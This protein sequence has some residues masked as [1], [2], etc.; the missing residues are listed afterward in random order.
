MRGILDLMF[1]SSLVVGLVDGFNMPFRG[2]WPSTLT[3]V[4]TGDR[5]DNVPSGW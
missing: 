3:V 4:M 2:E 1:W 5:V